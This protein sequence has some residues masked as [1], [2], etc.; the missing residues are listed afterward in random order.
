MPETRKGNKNTLTKERASLLRTKDSLQGALNT[1]LENVDTIRSNYNEKK[2]DVSW[3]MNAYGWLPSSKVPN[4]YRLAA[5][6]EI[7]RV[8]NIA[9]MLPSDRVFQD[10][11]EGNALCEDVQLL[12]KDVDCL[13]TKIELVK[14]VITHEKLL[15]SSTN[16]ELYLSLNNIVTGESEVLAGC[17]ESYKTWLKDN[18]KPDASEALEQTHSA[19]MV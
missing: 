5:I 11:T 3:L 18:P 7:E 9:K 15:I 6:N 4:H 10:S 19:H 12:R 13:M 1:L 8:A 14:G 2:P 16:S 17:R